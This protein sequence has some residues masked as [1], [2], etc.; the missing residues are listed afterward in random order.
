[1]DFS[2]DHSGFVFVSYGLVALALFGLIGFVFWRDRKL[3]K[4][5]KRLNE[6]TKA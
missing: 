1:M 5:L 6:S 4:Q 2:A 3:A